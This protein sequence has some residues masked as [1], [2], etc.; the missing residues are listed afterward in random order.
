M[1]NWL[2][3]L[4][5]DPSNAYCTK[6]FHFHSDT[7]LHNTIPCLVNTFRCDMVIQLLHTCSSERHDARTLGRG[8]KFDA[9]ISKKTKN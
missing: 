3:R 9:I 1:T 7:K 4:H 8:A 6:N 5:F 2:Q